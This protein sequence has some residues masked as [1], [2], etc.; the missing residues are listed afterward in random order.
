MRIARWPWYEPPGE[1]SINHRKENSPMN[2]TPTVT[3][4]SGAHADTRLASVAASPGQKGKILDARGRTIEVRPLNAIETYRLLK[5][6]KATGG[7]GYFGMAAMAASVRGID[8]DPEA[9]INNDR[10][11]E[12]MVQRLGN[13]GLAAVA[14][15]LGEHE[16]E[17]LGEAPKS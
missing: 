15:A 1:F 9:F 12:A 3:I 17:E 7:E 11:I 8:G 6:T 14:K 16:E 2:D 5:I 10:D 13:D 4:H